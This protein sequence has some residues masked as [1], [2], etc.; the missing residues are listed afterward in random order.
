MQSFGDGGKDWIILEWDGEALE[1]FKQRSN[2]IRNVVQKDHLG[3]SWRRGLGGMKSR[4][5][6]TA[7]SRKEI[8]KS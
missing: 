5:Y 8:S 3:C 4:W 2:M 1:G 7:R 6:I